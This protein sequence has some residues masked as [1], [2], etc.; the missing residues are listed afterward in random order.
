M[1]IYWE[2]QQK[3]P[4]MTKKHPFLGL[5]TFKRP[6]TAEIASENTRKRAVFRA[7][8]LQNGQ[9]GPPT[10]SA[11]GADI[12]AKSGFFRFWGKFKVLG[13]A[14]VLKVHKKSKSVGVLA[15]KLRKMTC[16]R[17]CPGLT[18]EPVRKFNP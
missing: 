12:G 7:F 13:F 3:T 2:K 8:Y 6:K 14:H 16:A 5:F 11:G 4:K 17:L 15:F 1:P 9:K 18:S 10:G